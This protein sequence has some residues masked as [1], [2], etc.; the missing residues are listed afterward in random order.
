MKKSLIT[1]GVLSIIA[2]PLLA[3]NALGSYYLV[4]NETM[5]AQS[6]SLPMQHPISNPADNADWSG[7]YAGANIGKGWGMIKSPNNKDFHS[8]KTNGTIGGLH[9]GYNFQFNEQYLL[10]LEAQLSFSNIKQTEYDRVNNPHSAYVNSAKLKHALSLNAK[11]GYMVDNFLP[12]VTAG[13]TYAKHEYGLGCDKSYAPS[14]E[15]C[16]TAFNDSANKSSLGFNI[17]IGM[18][19]K[20]TDNLSM[21]AEFR[22]TKFGKKSVNLYDPN[23]T[24]KTRREFKPDMKTLNLSFTYHFP[25]D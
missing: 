6:E 13:L 19:Y 1:L 7:F 2:T 8:Y 15:R 12:Y 17:G 20:I 5:A 18:D 23:H 11:A 24:D 3:E 4:V 10:G 16:Q 25:K 14:T 22:Y 21:G 9:M